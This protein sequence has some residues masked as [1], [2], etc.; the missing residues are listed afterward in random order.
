MRLPQY[1]NAHPVT[2]HSRYDNW[3]SIRTTWHWN[4]S[5]ESQTMDYISY[6]S[7]HKPLLSITDRRQST[8]AWLPYL[9]GD[10][11]GINK[12]CFFGQQIIRIHYFLVG[13]K[14]KIS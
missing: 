12:L 1:D 3:K 10:D 7:Y 5:D 13:K 14:L 4:L 6:F 8:Q 2:C 9:Y 11:V